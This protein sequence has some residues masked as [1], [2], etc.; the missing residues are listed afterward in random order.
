MKR[1]FRPANGPFPSFSSSPGDGASGFLTSPTPVRGV[2][3]SFFCAGS[4][5]AIAIEVMAI[6]PKKAAPSQRIPAFRF[7]PAPSF[8]IRA[9]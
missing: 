4:P 1:N 6:A 9:F 3:F 5:A 8:Q 2:G 7:I